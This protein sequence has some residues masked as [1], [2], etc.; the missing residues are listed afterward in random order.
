MSSLKAISVVVQ[1]AEYHAKLEIFLNPV[2]K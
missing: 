2:Y 1:K